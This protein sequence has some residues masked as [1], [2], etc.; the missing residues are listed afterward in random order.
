MKK[1]LLL[2]LFITSNLFAQDTIKLKDFSTWSI[3]PSFSTSH[4]NMDV[5]NLV[6]INTFNPGFDV[7]IRKQLSHFTSI[8]AS[9]TNTTLQTQDNKLKYTSYI[10]QLDARLC[11]N[12]TNGFI[13]DN[14][15]RTQ[16]Y[17]Y[18]GYGILWYNATRDNLDPHKGTTRVIP[19]G[20][21]VK[22]NVNNHLSVV[23]DVNYNQ[24][25]T[26]RLDAYINSLTAKDGYSK[27]SLGITYTFGKKKVLEWSNPYPYVSSFVHSYDTI[28]II[29]HDT[30]EFLQKEIKG[31]ESIVIYYESGKW[32][33]DESYLNNIDSLIAKAQFEDKDIYIESYTDTVGSNK[34]NLE[35]VLK[36]AGIIFQYIRNFYPSERIKAKMHDESYAIETDNALNRK[37]IIKIIK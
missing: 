4:G 17:G 21:G 2:L 14:W 22:Y 8:Q 33:L 10:N 9:Y 13:I 36:R 24:S 27:T 3:T 12:L 1:L 37:S 15:K 5:N 26:D 23:L 7:N 16:L 35:I 25:N 18:I 30:V 31:P 19:I 20:V 34:R 32:D 28:V 29:N 6:P 11:V